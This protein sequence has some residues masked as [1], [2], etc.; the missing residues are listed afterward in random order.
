MRTATPSSYLASNQR[1]L[2]I[3]LLSSEFVSINK[4]VELV[5]MP[6]RRLW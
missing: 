2:T 6:A 1:S 5:L 3:T 4:R